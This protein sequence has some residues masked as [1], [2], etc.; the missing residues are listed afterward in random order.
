MTPTLTPAG[1]LATGLGE[2]VGGA[3]AEEDGGLVSLQIALTPCA[4]PLELLELL[5]PLPPE[6]HAARV[7]RTA[8]PTAAKEY[9]EER[10]ASAFPAGGITT[11]KARPQRSFARETYSRRTSW[12]KAFT[13]AWQG[14]PPWVST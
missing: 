2:L 5:L 3:L 14:S 6:E 11:R 7:R 1:G 8:E 9:V 10:M 13:G 4:L 12:N